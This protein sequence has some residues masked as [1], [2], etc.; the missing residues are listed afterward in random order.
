MRP[1]CRSQH[2]LNVRALWGKTQKALTQSK[3]PLF[4]SAVLFHEIRASRKGALKE[5][6]GCGTR[7][8]FC[9]RCFL[10]HTKICALD[11]IVRLHN[12]AMPRYPSGN[13]AARRTL[14]KFR[15]ELSEAADARGSGDNQIA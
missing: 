15:K 9:P 10:I 8:L 14:P 1:R 3:P 11:P 6:S 12:R 5:S 4:R 13:R 2:I 7:K